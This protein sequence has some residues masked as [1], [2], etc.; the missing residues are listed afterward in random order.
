MKRKVPVFS[1]FFAVFMAMFLLLGISA[2]QTNAA[3][4]PNE[5]N[6]SLNGLIPET[7]LNSQIVVK[8]GLTQ[9]IYTTDDAIVEELYVETTVDADKDGKLDRIHLML[10]RPKTDPGVKVPVIYHISPYNKNLATYQNH[11]FIHDLVPVGGNGQPPSY[12]QGFADQMGAYAA[13]NLG[14]L[15]NYFVPR[16][17]A[18][19]I[20]DSLG[21]AGSDGCP[22]SGGKEEISAAKSVVDW[23]N[24]RAKAFTKAGAEVSATSW[25][26]GN[27]GM[28]GT[29]YEGTLA[30]AVATTGVAGLKT[31][32]PISAIS[33]WYDYYRANG[34]VVAPGGYQGEDADIH[35]KAILTR[36]NPGICKNVIDDLENRQDRVTGDYNDFWH[37]RNFLKDVA[38]VKSSVL[39][40]S[41]LK[42]WNVRPKHFAQW[43]EG[44]S[45]NNVPRKLWLY[46]GTHGVNATNRNAFQLLEH[47][48]FDYWLY[49]IENGIMD[50]P[51]VDVQR[52]DN[53]WSKEASWPNV[54][55]LSTVMHFNAA[56]ET[57]GGSLTLQQPVNSAG[58]TE[59]WIDDTKTFLNYVDDMVKYYNNRYDRYYLASN[60]GPTFVK[61]L[62]ANPDTANP[63]RLA[64]LTSEL[65]NP[66]R[67]SGTPEISIRASID[68]PVSNLTALLVDYGGSSPVIVTRG[69]TDPQNLESARISV[70]IVPNK[71]YTFK[72][73]MEPED[74]VIQKGH[75]LGI[76]LIATDFESSIIPS[77]G[78]KIT[79]D[80]SKSQVSLPIVGGT[81]ALNLTSTADMKTLVNQL[82]D[83][84]DIKTNQAAQALNLHLTGVNQFEISGLADK[85]VKQLQGFKVLLD[86]QKKSG[87]ISNR[88]YDLLNK[89][90]DQLLKKW[91][92]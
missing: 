11:G 34:A 85:V 67:I 78:T 33:S 65:S 20:A 25:S 89:D 32:V 76:V 45:E 49:G 86:Q 8:D 1:Q 37:E 28:E 10:Y 38:D 26:T 22:V 18:V 13:K 21:T 15:A 39:I 81:T 72:W 53:S 16:G 66:V 70:P 35:A 5:K 9:P 50:E 47:R 7:A 75:R 55:T 90:V 14:T 24:G 71:S 6:I 61:N 44:L 84:G 2:P 36:V 88:A 56:K 27:V 63:N 79:V 80:P 42:D 82:Q 62:L 74:Y 73:A 4:K 30:N 12:F 17:Y 51:I 41:G 59:S 31:I 64:Y 40:V 58:V 77:S 43:W 91:Q 52:E 83:Q 23:L 19:I 57:G 87:L 54:N 29:S 3:E 46:Q 92:K 69:W 68:R 60:Y 48:W